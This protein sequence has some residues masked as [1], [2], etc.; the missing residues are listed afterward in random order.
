MLLAAAPHS[1]ADV[2]PVW[3][4]RGRGVLGGCWANKRSTVYTGTAAGPPSGEI[5]H[6]TAPNKVSKSMTDPRPPT[7]GD[8]QAELDQLTR[9][10]LADL[11]RR[12]HQAARRERLLGLWRGGGMVLYAL[13]F[14]GLLPPL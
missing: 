10:V 7:P 3:R 4:G 14:L 6:S 9:G 13:V 5:R 1:G 2:N 8:V 12:Q 11:L